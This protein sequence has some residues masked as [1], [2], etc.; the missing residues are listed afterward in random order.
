MDA[1][2]YLGYEVGRTGAIDGSHLAD[3]FLYDALHGASPAGMN[4]A[5]GPLPLV[6]QQH[7]DAVGCRDADAHALHVGHQGINTLQRGL[8]FIVRTLQEVLVH[9][10]NLRQVH[11]M[12]HHQTV[13]AHVQQLAQG[14]AVLSDSL[15]VVPTIAVDV[16]RG[17]VALAAAPLSGAA[18][19]H[20][21]GPH[22]VIVQLRLSHRG[23]E[24]VFLSGRHCGKIR[25]SV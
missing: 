18:E 22:L 9:N 25:F 12:G 23:S 24:N 2:S 16:K 8:P 3:G 7:G 20:H 14:L 11:L 13:V 15:L 4:G 10:G 1:W 5:D 19:G 21:L 6:K 17:I